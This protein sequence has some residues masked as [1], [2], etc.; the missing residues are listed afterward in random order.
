MIKHFQRSPQREA[1]TVAL[2]PADTIEFLREIQTAL[3]GFFPAGGVAHSTLV[4]ILPISI[5]RSESIL[6]SIEQ[7]HSTEYAVDG[8]A[9][10]FFEARCL[11]DSL[12]LILQLSLDFSLGLIRL[13]SISRQS[14]EESE[15]RWVRRHF[16]R[17]AVASLAD[18]TSKSIPPAC[19]GCVDYYGVFHGGNRLICGIHPFGVESDTCTDHNGGKIIAA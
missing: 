10:L 18:S 4:S 13:Q 12:D 2:S 3:C 14:T 15:G 1:P 16:S 19:V 11:G 6:F 7:I 9:L 17:E 5:D 8:P